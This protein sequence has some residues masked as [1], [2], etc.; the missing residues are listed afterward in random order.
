MAFELLYTRVFDPL[1]DFPDEL[2][3]ALRYAAGYGDAPPLQQKEWHDFKFTSAIA[4]DHS[5]YV[6]AQIVI[7]DGNVVERLF[8][9]K[10]KDI[11]LRFPQFFL[12]E[13]EEKNDVNKVD[14]SSLTRVYALKHSFTLNYTSESTSQPEA[15][16]WS[17]GEPNPQ[18]RLLNQRKVVHA[19]KY[20]H[21]HL[22]IV[23][24]DILAEKVT[25][26]IFLRVRKHLLSAISAADSKYLLNSEDPDELQ[27]VIFDYQLLSAAAIYLHATSSPHRWYERLVNACAG[28]A[29]RTEA[30]NSALEKVHSGKIHYSWL[31]NALLVAYFLRCF[32]LGQRVLKLHDPRG[33]INAATRVVLDSNSS[34]SLTAELHPLL[35]AF[36]KVTPSEERA[37]V[38][39]FSRSSL[40]DIHSVLQRKAPSEDVEGA[41]KIALP[42]DIEANVNYNKVAKKSD[43]L[44]SDETVYSQ[45]KSYSDYTTSEAKYEKAYTSYETAVENLKKAAT[46]YKNSKT[47]VIDKYNGLAKIF[48]QKKR[49]VQVIRCDARIIEWPDLL[50]AFKQYMHDTKGR[51]NEKWDWPQ[52]GSSEIVL[53][54][55][56]TVSFLNDSSAPAP[57]EI[58]S[59]M[60]ARAT[61]DYN[62]PENVYESISNI[63]ETQRHRLLTGLFG[64]SHGATE[65]SQQW[66]AII[67]ADPDTHP[68]LP[69]TH[70]ILGGDNA[71]WEKEASIKYVKTAVL[72]CA[73]DTIVHAAAISLRG[74]YYSPR[75]VVSACIDLEPTTMG[76]VALKFIR[77]QYEELFYPNT[78]PILEGRILFE[79]LT[80]NN[81]D[82]EEEVRAVFEPFLAAA[83]AAAAGNNNDVQQRNGEMKF[84][85]RG[86]TFPLFNMISMSNGDVTLVNA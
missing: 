62:L 26:K 38:P 17:E 21:Q 74:K 10:T 5:Q 3:K 25:T 36:E 33:V 8:G 45:L 84:W 44:G 24:S 23:V 12:I 43:F 9:T 59:S 40:K 47:N 66:R 52:E 11:V 65:T 86:A 67:D 13:Y 29:A 76:R 34:N 42:S 39:V 60:F 81:K 19:H 61:V 54:A 80:S 63:L 15:T 20:K 6:T 56:H 41:Q 49:L 73:N 68:M 16:W 27:H 4:T 50:F 71:W 78:N 31:T 72:R 82:S 57:H 1:T 53:R 79:C 55:I 48:A 46:E 77:T 64:T 75:E 35:F 69:L 14:E 2:A 37:L 83:S 32:L 28:E 18:D 51:G 30:I 7:G 58:A 22:Y 85:T 70:M